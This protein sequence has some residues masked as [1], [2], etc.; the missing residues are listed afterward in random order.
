MIIKHGRH[1][2]GEIQEMRKGLWLKR[3]ECDLKCQRS[4]GIDRYMDRSI[5]M[6]IVVNNAYIS[7]RKPS[8]NYGVHLTPLPSGNFQWSDPPP[9]RN[10]RVPPCGGGGW[11]FS[12]TTHCAFRMLTG[13][14]GKLWSHGIVG[15][16][17]LCD[18]QKEWLCRRLDHMWKVVFN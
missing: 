11:I 16:E 17:R 6:Q 7:L 15:E 4:V 13:W 12:G 5:E 14:A 10:F 2:F 9:P 1:S 3:W 8:G 18:E